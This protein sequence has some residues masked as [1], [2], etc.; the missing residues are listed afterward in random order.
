MTLAASGALALA[1]GLVVGAG[2]RDAGGPPP[3]SGLAATCAEAQ[4][5]WARSAASQVRM[6]AEDPSSLR[7]GFRDAADALAGVLPPEPVAEDWQSVLD[8]LTAVAAAVEERAG[9][10][11]EDDDAVTSA[12]ANAM[13]DLDTAAMTA[14]SDRVTR[15][16]KED[17]AAGA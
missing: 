12:V 17:C 2:T 16:L 6:S 5:A 4:G 9:D 11:V 13:G 1:L 3:P 14:A 8:Y 15:Y 7:R 10:A